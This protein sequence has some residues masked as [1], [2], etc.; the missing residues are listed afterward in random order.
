[1]ANRENER[2]RPAQQDDSTVDRDEEKLRGMDDM[3]L[4]DD[5]DVEFEDTDDLDDEEV[6][7]EGESNF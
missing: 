2:I 5:E 6:E 7:E 3:G 1:M 4:A